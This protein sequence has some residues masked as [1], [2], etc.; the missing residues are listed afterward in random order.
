MEFVARMAGNSE[1]S[2]GESDV[3]I[4][5]IHAS[6]ID[7]NDTFQILQRSTST[8]F[9]IYN[10]QLDK[11]RSEF[12]A[13]LA[14]SCDMIELR[15]VR[16]MMFSIIEIR[17][18]SN[19]LAPLVKRKSG[20]YLKDKLIKDIYNLY[21]FGE[22][23][24]SSLPKHMLKSE[25]RFVSQEVQAD[26]VLSKSLFA[27]KSELEDVKIELLKKLTRLKQDLLDR[28]IDFGSSERVDVVQ[29]D[30]P[31]RTVISGASSQ[32]G[33][34]LQNTPSVDSGSAESESQPEKSRKMLIA[35][36]SLLH[37][38]NTRQLKV[39]DIP[40]EKLVK[41][42]DRLS[43]TITH[44][45]NFLSKHTGEHIDLVLLANTDDLA[46][47]SVSPDELIKKLD[48][49]ISELTAFQDLHHF[50]ICQLPPRFDFRNVN[51]KA[52]RFNYLKTLKNS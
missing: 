31:T 9:R 40:S 42:G 49:S 24:L 34:A 10:E 25:S 26:N 14:D 52:T 27:T 43:G 28:M 48:E 29:D 18:K 39:D 2:V 32:P 19:Q 22:G 3:S 12:M 6:G 17:T 23:S 50:F 45:R 16:D 11:S 51:S 41:K 37:W 36:D 5:D 4:T 47:R 44:C 15:Y 35:G 30:N 46:S 8:L 13:H 21:C 1:N 38:V 33:P 7:C 20:E